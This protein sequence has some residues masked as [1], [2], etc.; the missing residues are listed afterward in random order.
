MAIS[1]AYVD[2]SWPVFRGRE[3][4][5]VWSVTGATGIATDTV[6]IIGRHGRVPKYCIG[7]GFTYTISGS[8]IT[9]TATVALGNLTTAVIIGFTPGSN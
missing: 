2:E 1:A 5:E 7:S 8:T 4:W 9:L 3:I 6:A